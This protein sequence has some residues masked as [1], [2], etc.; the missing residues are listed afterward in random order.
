MYKF[1]V[2]DNAQ[3]IWQDSKVKFV[4]TLA[5]KLCQLTMRFDSYKMCFDHMIKHHLRAMSSI[6][7][8]LRKE[9]NNLIDEQQIQAVIKSPSNSWKIISQN[10]MH[11]E[12]IKKFNNVLRYLKLEV[13]HLK[14]A[15]PKNSI[16]IAKFGSCKTSRPKRKKSKIE[17]AA[18]K[19][20]KGLG[21]S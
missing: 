8:K 1:E 2:Y 10:M 3:S 12:N 13:E 19:V 11:N 14:A 17:V 6:I 16:Y 15:K 20:K 18:D 21:P 9:K 5:T 4:R 7:C